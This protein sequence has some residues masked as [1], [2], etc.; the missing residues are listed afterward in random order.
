MKGFSALVCHRAA[1]Q[2]WIMA[3]RS[4]TTSSTT[5][6]QRKSWTAL[7]LQSQVS[8]VFGVDIHPGAILG[9]GILLDHGTGI[10]IG[11]T[12]VLG[13]GCTLLHGVTL[14]GTGKD[15]GDRHPKIGPHVLIGAGAKIL[16][17]IP[18]GAGA[19]IGAGSIVLRPIPAGATAVGAPAK[20]IGRALDVDPAQNPD[21]TL[22]RVG[23]LHKSLSDNTLRTARTSSTTTGNVTTDDDDEDF[24]DDDDDD[25]DSTTKKIGSMT[26]TI[27]DVT[28]DADAHT[29][30]DDSSTL[31]QTQRRSSTTDCE[32]KDLHH[33]MES[34]PQQRRRSTNDYERKGRHDVIAEPPPGCV[35]PYRDYVTMSMSAPKDSITI[36]SSGSILKPYECTINELGGTFFELDTLNV[37]HFYWTVVKDRLPISL[38]S[39]TRLT[40]EEINTVM[41]KLRMK[42]ERGLTVTSTTAAE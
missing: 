4:V 10:V 7:F 22:D 26:P 28:A 15:H 37:G 6:K 39:N 13:D 25:E 33:G 21:C 36:C 2:K 24:D 41:E 17:N 34:R 23:M 31:P 32:D 40:T 35:C 27:D 3:Q 18:I 30:D 8:A 11:E 14:G 5:K 42:H 9:A 12:A 19:K 29:Q 38:A 16:G 1:H 20:I